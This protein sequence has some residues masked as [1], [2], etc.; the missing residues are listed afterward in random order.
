MQ[1]DVHGEHIVVT[2][3]PVCRIMLA[4]QSRAVENGGSLLGKVSMPFRPCI[5][6]S[7]HE[8]AGKQQ[9]KKV[10]VGDPIADHEPAAP[11][12]VGRGRVH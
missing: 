3:P 6:K 1:S 8:Y 2:P 11:E 7:E 10:V 4:A 12:L 5:P 9:K